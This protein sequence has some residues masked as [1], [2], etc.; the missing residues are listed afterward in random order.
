MDDSCKTCKHNGLR[1]DEEPCESC[2]GANDGYGQRG[3]RM[4]D[5]ISRHQ[6]I[7][8]LNSE[9]TITGR[10]NAE[11]VMGYVR[12]VK[13]RLERLPSA[14]PEPIK[15]NIEDF[16]KEDWERFKKEWRN[17]PITVLP[18]QPESIRCKDCRHYKDE[19]HYCDYFEWHFN[20]DDFCS[21]GEDT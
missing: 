21:K 16:N 2:C 17:M 4:D 19:I 3:D 18:A 11:A 6:A 13:D 5:L 14:Q 7:D 10:T 12:L 9:I 8:A 1:W 20:G 15:I